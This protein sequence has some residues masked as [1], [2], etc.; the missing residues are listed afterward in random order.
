MVLAKMISQ[1]VFYSFFLSKLQDWINMHIHVFVIA[2]LGWKINNTYMMDVHQPYH[3]ENSFIS[4]LTWPK[5][6]KIDF[7]PIVV[8]MA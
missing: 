5:C 6:S 7:G 1:I 4:C 3:E 8:Q 2:R